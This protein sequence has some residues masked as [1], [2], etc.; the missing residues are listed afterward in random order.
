MTDE[1]QDDIQD[2]V[3]QPLPERLP[4]PFTYRGESERSRR[5]S[6]IGVAFLA[7]LLALVVGGLFAFMIDFQSYS[8]PSHLSAPKQ[9]SETHL[10]CGVV[11]A[12]L[13]VAAVYAWWVR[14]I[15]TVLFQG[16]AVLLVLVMSAAAVHQYSRFQPFTGTPSVQPTATS[17]FVPCFSGS[18]GPGCN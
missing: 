13:F 18:N 10:L 6:A 2:A 8:D 15:G 9:I 1:V 16:A 11:V 14:S 5:A 4:S 7:D 12:I 3:P 17:T